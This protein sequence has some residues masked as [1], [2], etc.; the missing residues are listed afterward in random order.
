M[1][2]NP[3]PP[4]RRRWV[5]ISLVVSLLLAVLGVV[6]HAAVGVS[7][8]EDAFR[9]E[10]YEP[11]NRVFA[12]HAA[13]N[14]D[15]ATL[16]HYQHRGRVHLTRALFALLV[17][18]LLVLA[19]L[20][21]EAVVRAVRDYFG[22]EAAP[23]NLAIFRIVVPTC[24]FVLV[25]LEGPAWFATIPPELEKI[26]TGA[27]WIH[28]FGP[29]DPDVVSTLVLI[30]RIACVTTALGLFS[31]TSALVCTVLG[32]HLLGLPQFFGKVNH[33]HH[34][35]WF[36]AILSVCR[37][38]DVLALD[39]WRRAWRRAD[40]G[41]VAPP[42]PS[43]AYGLPLRI[44]WLMFGV[45]Y[46]FPGFWKLWQS[47]IDWAISDNMRNQ[48]YWKWH[49]LGGWTPFIRID[50]IPG[51]TELGGLGTFVFEMG[52]ILALF[53]PTIRRFAI[54]AGLGFHIGVKLFMNIFFWT[55]LAV[56]VVFVDWDRW[57]RR[58]GRVLHR[59]PLIVL[60][61][62]N[63]ELCRR[64]IGI[65]RT[66]DV[67]G[68]I[69]Y[70]NALDEAAVEAVGAGHIPVAER[71]RDMVGLRGSE[72]ANGYDA[73]RWIAARIPVLW[74]LWPFTY[75]PPVAAVGRRI[76]RKVADSRFCSIVKPPTA[77]PAAA[78]ATDGDRPV[79][80][81]PLVALAVVL[82][83]GNV[84][85]GFGEIVTGWPFSCYPT[86][87]A[88]RSTEKSILTLEIVREDGSVAPAD[89]SGLRER[90]GLPRLVGML[91]QITIPPDGPAQE[92]KL[93]AF[94][95]LYR[96]E[97]PEAAREAQLVRF[98]RDLVSTVP[99]EEGRNPL[100]RTLI[101]EYAP[102]ERRPGSEGE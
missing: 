91:H 60:Y 76:Y 22:A 44:S 86:F 5:R 70:V 42:G 63:C 12:E 95:S 54:A 35:L 80:Q 11:L 74:P 79:A 78:V 30:F 92:E 81:R 19:W 47:G 33:Y 9:G 10:S 4:S 18:E 2:T 71:M 32:L 99:G 85:F 29:S 58:L 24:L 20:R 34:L 98:Q 17:G 93:R 94:W 21:R 62:G 53:H 65:L 8:I 55:V 101:L 38:G 23:L 40:R 43:R 50:G 45:L 6:I 36:V 7:L 72:R 16:E 64:T 57:L 56:Y 41:V 69:H 46:F 26:P 100:E 68:R 31:R 73:Y 39:A 88:V 51:F 59:E 97:M 13:R 77:D 37:S 3:I 61:D 82:V 66:L 96:A 89:V 75:L 49:D 14:P 87:S 48:L 83:V 52:F 102:G 25:G 84:A 27:G 1:S 28:A 15:L 67:L 90:L